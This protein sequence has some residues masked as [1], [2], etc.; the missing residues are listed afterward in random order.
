MQAECWL[1]KIIVFIKQRIAEKLIVIFALGFEVYLL[2]HDLE[3]TNMGIWLLQV[4]KIQY[5]LLVTLECLLR[6]KWRAVG[7][8]SFLPKIEVFYRLECTKGGPHK[9]ANSEMDVTNRAWSSFHTRNLV[10]LNIKA[11][12]ICASERSCYAISG[13]GVAYCPMTYFIRRY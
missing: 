12:Y 8:G 3:A 13:N 11:I 2:N 4:D 7:V 10:L 5:W 6:K 9:N 1:I